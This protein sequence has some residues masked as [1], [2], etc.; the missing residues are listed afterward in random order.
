MENDISDNKKP[1]E[2]L[3][4]KENTEELKKALTNLNSQEVNIVLRKYYYLQ[5]ISQIGA[6]L[7]LT[8]RA[9]EGKLYRIKKKLMKE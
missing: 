3:I 5:P 2:Q 6:E 7:G 9:V 1:L 8:T 4:K